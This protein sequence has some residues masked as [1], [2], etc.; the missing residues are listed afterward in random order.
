MLLSLLA[1]LIVVFLLGAFWHLRPTDSTGSA[2][3]FVKPEGFKIVG[4]IFFGRPDRVAILDCYLKQ[5]LVEN[6]GFLDK[7]H[8]VA[9]TDKEQDLKYLDELVP[10]SPS[11]SRIDLPELG[12]SSIWEHAIERGTLYIKIDDDVVGEPSVM[13]AFERAMRYADVRSGLRRSRSDT[14]DRLHEIEAP[15]VVCRVCKCDQ[16]SPFGLAPL[17][18]GGHSGLS[19]RARTPFNG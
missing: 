19:A 18:P 6:G 2:V 16:Q 13:H 15:E 5:N 1:G 10:T 3:A 17:S 14:Q 7:V 9:N 11:Y 12:F 4:L 8:W